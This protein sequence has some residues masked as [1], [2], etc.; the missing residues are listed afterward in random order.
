MDLRPFER[1]LT[2]KLIGEACG[3]SLTRDELAEGFQ[4]ALDDLP[5]TVIDVPQVLLLLLLF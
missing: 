4:C 1:E 2:S 5:E 3:V